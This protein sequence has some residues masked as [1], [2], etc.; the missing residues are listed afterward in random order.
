MLAL[1]AYGDVTRLRFSTTVS[2][3]LGY[4]VSAYAV[5]G[6][7]IDTGFPAIAREFAVWLD[8]SALQGVVITHHHEDHA[9][10]LEL[11]ARGGL[12]VAIAP[13]ALRAVQDL[14]LLDMYRRVCWGQ[15]PELT[16][17]IAPF[18]ARGLRLI[19]L[20]GHSPD[21]HV[22]WDEEHGTLFAG[23]LFIGVKVRIAQ[24]DEVVAQQISSLR[25]AISLAPERVFCAHRGP[26]ANPVS[27]LKAKADWLEEITG[28]IDRLTEQGLSEREITRRVLGREGFVAYTSRGKLSKRNL[29]RSARRE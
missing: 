16:T 5:R 11:V 28:A 26:V 19:H 14:G 18:V 20:P 8:D 2:R 13:I 4:E 12:P 1:E 17:P 15:P 27:A 7:L 25:A 22:I 29:I 9:G 10:N 23:D 21:H 6:M 3:A 24:E